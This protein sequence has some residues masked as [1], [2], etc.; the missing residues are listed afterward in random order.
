MK[1]EFEEKSSHVSNHTSNGSNVIRVSSLKKSSEKPIEK[2][3]DIDSKRSCIKFET[4]DCG[5]GQDDLVVKQANIEEKKFEG[6][7]ENFDSEKIE[8]KLIFEGIEAAILQSDKNDM[9]EPYA[10]ETPVIVNTLQMAVNSDEGSQQVINLP[11]EEIKIETKPV[12]KKRRRR[13]K[14]KV[15]IEQV[16]TEASIDSFN[17]IALSKDRESLF[18]KETQEEE[19]YSKHSYER[20]NSKKD[21]V[22]AQSVFN[23]PKPP[24]SQNQRKT[25]KVADKKKDIG[26]EDCQ[27]LDQ[28][29]NG[30]V[31]PTWRLRNLKDKIMLLIDKE[32]EESTKPIADRKLSIKSN[33]TFNSRKSSF[34][35]N[36]LKQISPKPCLKFGSLD[37]QES[38]EEL[39]F[40]GPKRNA[41]LLKFD[42]RELENKKTC[43][44]AKEFGTLND[45]SMSD[46]SE[47]K[48]MNYISEKLSFTISQKKDD[49]VTERE[50]EKHSMMK[51]NSNMIKI[52]K[53]KSDY[54][55]GVNSYQ[56]QTS[57][58]RYL[59]TR[60]QVISTNRENAREME[61]LTP[62]TNQ[63]ISN[64]FL[65]SPY[66][67]TI[68]NA[69]KSSRRLNIDK[70]GE[71]SHF[72][73]ENS[74]RLNIEKRR[75]QLSV[76]NCLFTIQI[77]GKDKDRSEFEEANETAKIEIGENFNPIFSTDDFLESDDRKFQ[78]RFSEN[79][80]QYDSKPMVTSA[81]SFYESESSGKEKRL[82]ERIYTG[83]YELM[84]ENYSIPQ[85]LSYGKSPLGSSKLSQMRFKSKEK[86]LINKSRKKEGIIMDNAEDLYNSNITNNNF[87]SRKGSSPSPAQ[88]MFSR[89]NSINRKSFKKKID[90]NQGQ[91]TFDKQ[92]TR[93]LKKLSNQVPN[94]VDRGQAP[95]SPYSSQAGQSQ[96]KDFRRGSRNNIQF[97][98]QAEAIQN[99]DQ[100]MHFYNKISQGYYG[101][102]NGNSVLLMPYPLGNQPQVP[103][104]GIVT[105]NGF[106]FN[107]PS[108]YKIPYF[109]SKEAYKQAKNCY[110]GKKVKLQRS[111]KKKM[112]EEKERRRRRR[113]IKKNLVM[114][115]EGLKSLEESKLLGTLGTLS[116]TEVNLTLKSRD[117]MASRNTRNSSKK[118][119]D[120]SEFSR[121]LSN[122]EHSNSYTSGSSS[123]SE[124]DDDFKVKQL[125]SSHHNIKQKS[126]KPVK[127]TIPF[128]EPENQKRKKLK[129]S[130]SSF[131]GHRQASTHHSR[132]HSI[133]KG[134]SSSAVQHQSHQNLRDSWKKNQTRTN[135]KKI[136]DTFS[137]ERKKDRV[138][139]KKSTLKKV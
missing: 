3:Y 89:K 131:F 49:L 81:S 46:P 115:Y 68:S 76:E 80:I 52:E 66:C 117:I 78:D 23:I 98:T 20:R 59:V 79:I 32:N 70:E 54:D 106:N 67:Y 92:H 84:Q 138:G 60:R 121:E 1:T 5:D 39:N 95:I 126:K 25:K 103:P 50:K 91:F 93:G 30:E 18:S 57:T 130:R 61:Y 94:L 119:V 100:V 99:N 109:D 137:R 33:F 14:T 11:L 120:F 74:M 55:S 22:F 73:G 64:N 27:I 101:V 122:D 10:K 4:F 41:D 7:E 116:N 127:F 51:I 24:I 112:R 31:L 6:K 132:H 85:S 77:Q 21:N 111:V 96:T 42:H 56:N 133:Q 108:G 17:D 72:N 34:F 37:N 128:N 82:V 114:H 86:K 28:L 36:E 19:S 97:S 45:K 125:T 118:M 75:S 105:Q 16:N 35:T 129:Y 69:D 102:R 48:E 104:S 15:I 63:D 29:I 2:K 110:S 13:Q 139:S 58:N 26:E 113:K 38:L 8:N 124:I 43:D 135:K 40:D 87:G 90:E 136:R 47:V 12:P 134:D 53:K 107:T 83:E 44:H 123:S 88:G 71:S 62:Q 65:E 9:N